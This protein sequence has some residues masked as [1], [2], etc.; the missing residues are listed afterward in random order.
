M[1]F[2]LECWWKMPILERSEAR[3]WV[4]DPDQDNS[5]FRPA[6]P[7][8]LSIRP[9]PRPCLPP[10]KTRIGGVILMQCKTQ[11]L[12]YNQ[13]KCK[14]ESRLVFR[15]SKYL[16][17]WSKI[18][19]KSRPFLIVA[20]LFKLEMNFKYLSLELEFTSFSYQL[21]P[22]RYL[23]ITAKVR[24]SITLAFALLTG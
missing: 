9:S 11:N 18:T 24:S 1:P 5:R 20:G 23:I 16:M 19:S 3:G 8:L 17:A 6:H 12:S 21:E 10:S 4:R 7:E 15:S 13:T 22:W 2:P 14:T